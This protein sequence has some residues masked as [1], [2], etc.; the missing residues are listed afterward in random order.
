MYKHHLNLPL[1]FGYIYLL[2]RQAL[3]FGMNELLNV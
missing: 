3:E 2:T 1:G